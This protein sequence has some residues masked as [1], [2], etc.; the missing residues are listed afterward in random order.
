MTLLLA[1]ATLLIGAALC[2][3]LSRAAP[4]RALGL[5]AA[6]ACL[7]AGGLALLGPMPAAG[8]APWPLLTLG[9]ATFSLSA[10]L[11]AAERTIAA[12]L[13]G[14]G[15]AALL[16]L[17]GAIAGPVRGFGAIFGWALLCLMGA[18]LSLAA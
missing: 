2:F 4:T 1:F 3:G 13:L 14:G 17:A 18:L 8:A 15:A 5:L 6:A 12:T 16:A 11:A 10:G 9:E 7:A